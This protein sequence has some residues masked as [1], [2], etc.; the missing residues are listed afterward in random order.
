[1]QLDRRQHALPGHM[2]RLCGGTGRAAAAGATAIHGVAG[3]RARGA[4]MKTPLSLPDSVPPPPVDLP[5]VFAHC[6]AEL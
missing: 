1:M 5:R 2:P 3:S 6:Q 4:T